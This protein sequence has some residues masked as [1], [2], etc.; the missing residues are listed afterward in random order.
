MKGISLDTLLNLFQ[1]ISWVFQVHNH[2]TWKEFYIYL[3]IYNLAFLVQLEPQENVASSRPARNN[4]TTAG[5]RAR[6]QK[7]VHTPYV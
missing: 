3:F 6:V 1:F 7:E 5:A 4:C 2:D